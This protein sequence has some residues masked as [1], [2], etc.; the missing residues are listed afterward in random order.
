MKNNKKESKVFSIRVFKE[1]TPDI[2]HSKILELEQNCLDYLDP[3]PLLKK[4]VKELNKKI[5]TLERK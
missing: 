1:Y 4:Q 3:L 5:K 2:L